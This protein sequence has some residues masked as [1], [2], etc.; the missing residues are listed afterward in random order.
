MP[1]PR[2]FQH[3]LVHRRCARHR[4][5]HPLSFCRLVWCVTLFVIP[6]TGLV[7][8]PSFPRRHDR[9]RRYH[10]TPRRPSSRRHR[11][12]FRPPCLPCPHRRCLSR[13]R[14]RRCFRRYLLR[15][16]R[17]LRNLHSC[18]PLFNGAHTNA[19]HHARRAESASSIFFVLVGLKQ[20][21]AEN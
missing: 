5:L 18:R 20:N 3:P 14:R 19:Q 11:C 12:H 21:K 6:L 15:R 8:R 2:P 7:S 10:S 17:P 1:S 9:L 4:L 13:R 16:P